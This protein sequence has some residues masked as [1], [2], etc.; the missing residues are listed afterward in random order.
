MCI[1]VPEQDDFHS[2]QVRF[3]KKNPCAISRTAG[4]KSIQE[5][6]E[7]QEEMSLTINYSKQTISNDFKVIEE[8]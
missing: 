2:H 6:E 8:I 5:I 7:W 1:E 4:C 3:I